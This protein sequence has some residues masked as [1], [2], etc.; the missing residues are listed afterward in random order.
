MRINTPLMENGAVYHLDSAASQCAHLALLD[1]DY[2]GFS[3]S[4]FL[5]CE[6]FVL[7]QKTS[8]CIFVRAV[9]GPGHG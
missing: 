8:C 7:R 9:M 1:M 6:L 3:L 4:R 2:V 5:I